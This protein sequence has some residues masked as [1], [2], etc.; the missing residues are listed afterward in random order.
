MLC[1][2][3]DSPIFSDMIPDFC[4]SRRKN[5]KRLSAAVPGATKDARSSDVVSKVSTGGRL[6]ANLAQTTRNL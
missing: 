5:L 6:M 1:S 4:R 3:L 2:V